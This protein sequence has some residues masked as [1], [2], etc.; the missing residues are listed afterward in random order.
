MKG[1]LLAGR[2][3]LYFSLS[4]VL[5]LRKCWST[6]YSAWSRRSER[7]VR[8]SR[9][10]ESGSNNCSRG[11]VERGAVITE[12][13]RLSHSALFASATGN[14][15]K[16]VGSVFSS[17][18][19]RQHPA[20]PAPAMSSTITAGHA[21]APLMLATLVWRF[22]SLVADPVPAMSLLLALTA[23]YQVV[24]AVASLPAAG[25]SSCKDGAAET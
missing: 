16:I 14:S 24:S 18:E 9:S 3:K 19:K 6:E 7:S 22:D 17:A 21:T 20:S 12:H 10:N 4:D 15:K 23:A 8:S 25:V 5:V 11:E 2:P 1:L 13:A